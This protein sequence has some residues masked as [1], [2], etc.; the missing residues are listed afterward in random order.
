M[1]GLH[2]EMKLQR[3][4]TKLLHVAA[5]VCMVR[6]VSFVTV[7]RVELADPMLTEQFK[8]GEDENR[9]HLFSVPEALPRYPILVLCRENFGKPTGSLL[10]CT[11]A[12]FQGR[13]SPAQYLPEE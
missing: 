7:L 12:L 13:T 6:M 3:E 10:W 2:A 4:I 9:I 11:R 1:V 8:A 5:H